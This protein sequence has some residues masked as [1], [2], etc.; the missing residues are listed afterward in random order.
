MPMSHGKELQIG[1]Q[2]HR[3]YAS[4][5]HMGVTRPSMTQKVGSHHQGLVHHQLQGVSVQKQKFMG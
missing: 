3:I 4:P 5:H 1:N 2:I